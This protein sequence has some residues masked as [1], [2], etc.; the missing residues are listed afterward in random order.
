MAQ[1]PDLEPS[2]RLAQGEW[3]AAAAAALL[4]RDQAGL[5]TL[6]RA[7]LA[8][9]VARATALLGSAVAAAAW[10]PDELAEQWLIE[11]V[12]RLDGTCLAVLHATEVVRM[13]ER[14][15]AL[16]DPD[17]DR[18]PP[19]RPE[20]GAAVRLLEQ[21]ARY[22]QT[23]QSRD[24]ARIAVSRDLGDALRGLASPADALVKAMDAGRL[25]EL[26][27]HPLQLQLF[28][29]YAVGAA[30]LAYELALLGEGPLADSNP[31]L[32]VPD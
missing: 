5:E 6:L 12:A 8:P 31:T 28:R 19:T 27:T 25:D 32:V 18:A 30:A 16:V 22:L 4:R 14:Y 26:L 17:P 2:Q 24:D 13:A 23:D 10:W 9:A 15:E 21:A 3:S 29:A 7:E 11:M 1:R 20:P